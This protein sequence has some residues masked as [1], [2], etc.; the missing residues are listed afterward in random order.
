MKFATGVLAGLTAVS[1]LASAPAQATAGDNAEKVRR[2]DIMLMVSAL[3]CRNTADGFQED[4]NRFSSAHLAELNASAHTLK[5]SL[6]AQYGANGA[7]RALDKM[8][9]G[10]ANTYGQGHPWLGCAELKQATRDLAQN[11]SPDAL[12]AA[13]DALLGDS[14]RVSLTAAF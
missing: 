13:A 10:M 3:R 8:S 14:G 1:M 6:E 4:Y 9:V 7:K 12:R 5:Q 2:L 11:R